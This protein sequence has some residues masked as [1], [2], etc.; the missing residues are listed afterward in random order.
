MTWQDYQAYKVQ[1]MMGGVEAPDI[2]SIVVECVQKSSTP[3][4]RE[5]IVHA[6]SV[7]T[8]ISRG[9]VH[10]HLSDVLRKLVRSNRLVKMRAR[11]FYTHG[12]RMATV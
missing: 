2:E 1:K 10:D 5:E 6:V 9:E 4:K 12:P 11:G 7:K 8:G 3:V